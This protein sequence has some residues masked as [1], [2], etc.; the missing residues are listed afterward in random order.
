MKLIH[1]KHKQEVIGQYSDTS[2]QTVIMSG[3]REM[4][5]AHSLLS[6]VL[7]ACL[8]EG[9]RFSTM[10]TKSPNKSLSA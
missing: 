1:T 8:K 10:D 6:W 2:G 4:Y 5:A 7:I 9:I 3:N